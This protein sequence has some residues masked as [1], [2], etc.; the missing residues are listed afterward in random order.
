MADVSVHV[1][2]S[3]NHVFDTNTNPMQSYINAGTDMDITI[4]EQVV[5]F[6]NVLGNTV[7]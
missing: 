7:K 3:R 5:R 4:L 2:E 6:G 1:T